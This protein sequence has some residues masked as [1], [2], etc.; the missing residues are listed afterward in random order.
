MIDLDNITLNPDTKE[1]KYKLVSDL[2]EKSKGNPY[3]LLK[4][5]KKNHP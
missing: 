1:N 4:L 2:Y 3:Q 5:W